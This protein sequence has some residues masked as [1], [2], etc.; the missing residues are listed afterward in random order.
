MRS[1]RVSD[2]TMLARG[3]AGSISRGDSLRAL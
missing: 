3:I 2:Q 1:A